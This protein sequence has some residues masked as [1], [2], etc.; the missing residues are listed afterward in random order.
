MEWMKTNLNSS[1]RINSWWDY[2]HWTNYFGNTNTVLRNEH[3]SKGMIG[4]VAHDFLIGTTQDL[5]DSMN[6]FDS[7]YVLFDVEI[8]GSPFGGKYGALN[9]LGC[10]HEGATSLDEQPG[11]SDCEFLHSPERIV[12]PTAQLGQC[13]ISESQQ[14]TG[15]P[16]YEMLKNGIATTPTYCVGATT[17][18]T[19]DKI[20]ATYSLDK[21]DSDGNLV[22]NKGFVRQIQTAADAVYAEMVYTTDG[23]WIENNTLVN[24]MIDAKTDF[25]RSNLYSGFYLKQLPGFTLV[26]DTNEIKIYRLDN[27]IGNKERYI[28][29]VESKKL[30]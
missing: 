20:M 29:P 11:T 16:A 28:D 27:F 13:T 8:I 1:D 2:G 19:G 6:Y 3:A 23:V 15:T 24:G 30:N 26:Y 21:Q 4:R 12:I 17:I 14:L 22:L 25:Y 5:I 7:Q 10:V 18:A 9:Y